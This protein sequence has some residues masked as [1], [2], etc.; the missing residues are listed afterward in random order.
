MFNRDNTV[1]GK[2]RANLSYLYESQ[3]KRIRYK[4]EPKK[5]SKMKQ[6]WI[7]GQRQKKKKG[8]EI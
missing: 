2:K 1:L 4:V 7:V 6:K 8:K 3:S 5:L